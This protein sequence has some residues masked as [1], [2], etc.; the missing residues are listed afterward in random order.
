MRQLATKAA[1]LSIWFP[2][3]ISLLLLHV[4]NVMQWELFPISGNNQYRL[5]IGTYKELLPYA[6][7][8]PSPSTVLF[9]ALP[10]I[11]LSLFHF[12]GVINN[13]FSFLIEIL[14][15]CKT[16]QQYC[17]ASLNALWRYECIRLRQAK[18]VRFRLVKCW[19]RWNDKNCLIFLSSLNYALENKYSSVTILSDS[20]S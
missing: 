8:D 20:V 17:W 19:R 18:A 2:N 5:E 4:R 11:P 1:C 9:C 12:L 3:E 16:V 6:V 15:D 10:C 14:Y 7:S 13:A